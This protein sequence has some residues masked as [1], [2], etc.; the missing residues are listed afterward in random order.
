MTPVVYMTWAEKRFPMNQQIM[1]DTCEALAREQNALL[2]PIGSIWRTVR[3]MYPEIELY[4]EDGEHASPYGDFLIASVLCKLLTEAL[5]L[6]M[7]RTG[8]D[9]LQ[10]VPFDLDMPVVIEDKDAVTVQLNR[11]WTDRILDMVRAGMQ[12]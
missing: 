8:L 3:E 6:D 9:F 10:G 2:A 11:D 7:S 1:I 5:P 12:G 4:Y